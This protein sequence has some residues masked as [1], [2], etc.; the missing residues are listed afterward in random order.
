VSRALELARE[1]LLLAM[2]LSAPALAAAFGASALVGFVAARAQV[3]DPAV[4][5]APRALA[6]TAALALG[7][8]WM[9]A[10][11]LRFTRALWDALPTLV[12]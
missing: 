5:H 1:S 11:L 10:T 6:V 3:S 7:G 8:A 2:L 9:G 12:P 4:S